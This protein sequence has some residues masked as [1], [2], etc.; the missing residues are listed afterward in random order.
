MLDSKLTRRGF[1]HT[2]RNMLVGT[3]ALNSG[4]IGPAGPGPELGAAAYG[5]GFRYR[6]GAAEGH[7]S[8]FP[9]R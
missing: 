8:Y 1:L 6:A 9:A 5:A 2:G 4:A 7:P 3:L